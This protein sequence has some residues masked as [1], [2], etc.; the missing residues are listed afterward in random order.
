M[1]HIKN[2]DLRTNYYINIKSIDKQEIK[3]IL[4]KTFSASKFNKAL[5][6]NKKSE[7]FTTI[8]IKENEYKKKNAI[9]C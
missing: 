8:N 2:A 7:K 9:A 1:R 3:I 5:N 6:I 4:S